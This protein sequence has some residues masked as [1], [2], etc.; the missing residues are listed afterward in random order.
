M[1]KIIVIITITKNVESFKVISVTFFIPDFNLLGY[2][3]DNFTFKV[4][5]WVVL[6][7]YD[8]KVI[9]IHNTFTV[10]CGKSKTVSIASSIMK[11][12]F[13]PSGRAKF[14]V[15]L[16]YCVAFRSASSACCLLKSLWFYSVYWNNYY[17][18]D[19]Q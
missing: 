16:I 12:N 3:L 9:R 19:N 11:N 14:P 7:W 2:E 6:H 18:I 4:L 1:R 5:Y 8:I 13:G 10:V 15:K 17:L